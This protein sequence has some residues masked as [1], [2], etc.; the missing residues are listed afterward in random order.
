M[1]TL[2]F[3]Q[4]IYVFVLLSSNLHRLSQ[5]TLL[6]GVCHSS[7]H[8]APPQGTFGRGDDR[9]RNDVS[10]VWQGRRLGSA[11]WD[12]PSVGLIFGSCCR[13]G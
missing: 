10:S 11:S 1:S 3:R 8:T 2:Y 9:D 12:T 6:S 5:S 4:I 13:A 7:P